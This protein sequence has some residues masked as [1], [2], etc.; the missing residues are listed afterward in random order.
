MSL[1]KVLLLFD[2]KHPFW[3]KELM[4]LSGEDPSALTRLEGEGLLEKMDDGFVLSDAGRER[5]RR[6]AEESWLDSEP[7]GLPKD[8]QIEKRRLEIALKFDR[9]FKGFHGTKQIFITPELSFFPN[10]QE[11]RLYNVTSGGVQ[12]LFP[13][14]PLV[15]EL[16]ERFPRQRH[17]AETD[18]AALE[19][20]IKEKNIPSGTFV[21]D[22]LCL[23][24]C[25]YSYYWR[26]T[27]PT[28][29]HGFL[30]KDRLFLRFL[31]DPASLRPIEVLPDLARF[32]LFLLDNRQVYLPGCFDIDVHEQ[33][34]FT[35][36]FWAVE[37]GED[38]K[39][40]LQKL[41][42]LGDLLAAPAA[43][44]DFWIIS[45]EELRAYDEK[46]ESFYEFVDSVAESV[47]R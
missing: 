17:P 15:E 6:W 9:G 18:L 31:S 24:Q 16:V 12:W 25:D 11:D 14:D 39:H 40:V 8:T 36:W 13:S 34:A 20:W 23:N 22:L 30:N 26:H 10:L 1:E 43:P 19:D 46:A 28:D 7:A 2:R 5:F 33:T 47:T 38:A 27:I 44:T 3:T 35:W 21:P 42:P 4:E 32:S 37:T 45:L 29:R 41:R